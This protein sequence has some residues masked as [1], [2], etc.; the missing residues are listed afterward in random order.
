MAD[1]GGLS[2]VDSADDDPSET[3]GQAIERR[4]L[5]L[6]FR[7]VLHFADAIGNSPNRETIAKAEKDDPSVKDP[8]Y[9]Q[10]EAALS[11][12]EQ[13]R[14]AGPQVLRARIAGKGG[15]EITFES[16]LEAPHELAALVADALKDLT[17]PPD[18]PE[19]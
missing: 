15:F 3:R 14:A 11:R 5:A 13:Q 4:R 9:R 16:P 18:T 17:S 2:A 8:T 6:G 12:L 7:Y 1:K 10:I 19:E